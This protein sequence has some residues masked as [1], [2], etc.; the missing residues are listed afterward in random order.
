MFTKFQND[1]SS[2]EAMVLNFLASQIGATSFKVDAFVPISSPEKSY[3]LEG[4]KFR[5]EIAVGASSQSFFENVQISVNGRSLPV[6]EGK[7]IFEEMANGLG[8]HKYKVS[9]NV[10]NPSTGQNLSAQKDFEYEVGQSSVAMELTDMNVVYIGVENHL[11][12]AA[13]GYSSNQVSVTANG[14]GMT[15]RKDGAST[16][17]IE[18]KGPATKDAEIIVTAGGK[19]FSKKVRVK[20]IPDPIAKL[21]GRFLEG[22]LKPAEFKGQTNLLAMLENFDFNAICKVASFE[23]YYIP[24]GGDPIS[25]LNSGPNFQGQVADYIAKAKFGDMYLFT[26]VKA[27]CPGDQVSRPLNSLQFMIK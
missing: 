9:I 1:A 5:S 26:N 23:M 20:R 15:L 2:S 10:K 17:I 8:G 24:K 16:Y 27:M 18:A 21:G 11:A 4:E 22:N 3:L 13:A 25:A 7:A 6:K 19:K 14:G 12:I